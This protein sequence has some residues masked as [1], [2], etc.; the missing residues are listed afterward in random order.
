MSNKA[1]TMLQKRKSTSERAEQYFKSIKRNLEIK[2]IFELERKKEVLE[3]KIFD[4][5]NFDLETDHNAGRS[6]LTQDQ[7]EARFQQ[8][9]E[10]S[11][12]LE[13][14]NLELESKREIFNKYFADESTN[15]Q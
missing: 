13:L 12:E 9:I 14:L 8:L 10:A 5:E 3:G 6:A 4:L 15:N 11:Y 1:L 7:A 2:L